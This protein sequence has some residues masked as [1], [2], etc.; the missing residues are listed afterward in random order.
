[1]VLLYDFTVQYCTFTLFIL[2]VI[3]LLV[4]IYISV[5]VYIYNVKKFRRFL[6][7]KYQYLFQKI[8]IRVVVREFYN[9][10]F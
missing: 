1:M 10:R 5:F 7:M 3:G 2:S 6:C 8:A 9:V 4:D